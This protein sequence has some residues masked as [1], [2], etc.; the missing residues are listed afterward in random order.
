NPALYS[1]LSN[2]A[3]IAGKWTHLA[4]VYNASSKTISLYVDG[5]LQT[6]TATVTSTFNA[7]RGVSIGKRTWNGADSG[8]FTGAIDDVRIYSFA[9]TAAKI[10]ALAVPLPA[11]VTFPDGDEVNAGGNLSV[12]LGG[13]GDVNVAKFRWSLD[14][15]ALDH[16]STAAGGG[17][18]TVPVAVGTGIGDRGFFVAAVDAGGR[19]GPTTRYTF[20]V[21]SAVSVSGV[22]LDA[23]TFTP[24]AGATV[25]LTPGGRITT[26]A[27]DGSYRFADFATGIYTI[28]AAKG[29]RCGLSGSV[30]A[31]VTDGAASWDIYVF[32]YTDDLGYTCTESTAALSTA[33]STLALTG[34]DAVTKVALPFEFPFYGAS[35]SQ[36]WVDTNGLIAFDEPTA[37]QPTHDTATASVAPFWDD[38]VADGSSTI[39]TA[40]TGTGDAATFTVQW[41][42]VYLKSSSGQRISFEA[43]IG[44]T[45][46]VSF[47]YDSLDND[48]EKGAGAEVGIEA[49]DGEDGLSY[50]VDQP[51]LASGRSVVFNQPAAVDALDEHTLSGRVLNSA[52]TA[53]A[54]IPVTLDPSGKT[55][56]TGSDGTWRFT[57]L[58]DDSYTATATG[59]GRCP[60]TAA[61]QVDLAADTAVDLRLAPD[62][63]G[64][65]YACTLGAASWQA[66]TTLLTGVTGDDQS[67]QTTLPFP[68]VFH[69][70]TYN[71]GW[72]STNGMIG[73]G[74]VQTG[75]RLSVNPSMPSTALPN[76]YVAPFWDDLEID[77]SAGVYTLTT[78]TAPNRTF[79]VEWRNAKFRPSGPDRVTFEV[80][81]AEN[82]QI[83]FHYGTLT[84]PLQ[85]GA[86]ATVGL[87]SASGTVAAQYLFQQAALTSNSSITYTPAVTGAV[88][89]TVTVA[90]TGAAAAGVPVTLNPGNKST[91]TAAD[92]TY[93][94][95]GLPV[96]EYTVAASTGD[97]RC[98]GQSARES[99]ARGSGDLTVDLS[100]MSEG[101]EFGYQC[102]SG[103]VTFVPG[104]VTED[105]S[106]DEV[107]WQ[108][109]PPFPV[110]LYG[111][112]YTSAWINSNGLIAFKD[113]MYFGWI[114]STPET[115]PTP[116]SE[117]KPDAAVYAFWDDWV[118]DAATSKIATKTS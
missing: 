72:I 85:Q 92:G 37:S 62:Y 47:A 16:E 96:G 57:S 22:V 65:G 79:V 93:S 111:E 100:V 115:L 59:P 89:G 18:V 90:V 46:A 7:T 67:V 69:G 14:L 82:G 40:A 9:E 84:T 5:V 117:G 23:A 28:T 3:P 70:I 17:S 86:A 4:G 118:V 56:T 95:V 103:P 10:A 66:G 71:A 30:Q 49:P 12:T 19:V 58:V 83:S 64:M 45:G 80:K 55:V 63:G 1:V 33:G 109:N 98:A 26:T 41:Q 113:P 99:V 101:D 61:Q 31:D 50:S 108:K 11:T 51:N 43:T 78:G 39:K 36:A 2:A 25:T 102:T 104:D 44:A 35:Y 74:S 38:L 105:W 106:G 6:A 34:D 77:A 91:T 42:N 88:K 8:F 114:G 97:T 81:F 48:A 73:F 76:A 13:G 68:V 112:S 60:L 32:P 15:D 116:G 110:K 20:T 21:N 87:E 54:G 52:G 53:V 27:A 24:V 29:G 75:T 94:F 107:T